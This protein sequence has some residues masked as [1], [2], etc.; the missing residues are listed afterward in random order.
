LRRLILLLQ[1]SLFIAL[2]L[3]SQTGKA[4]HAIKKQERSEKSLEKQYDKSKETALKHRYKIQSPEVK[5][6]M[7]TSRKK[8]D[9]YYKQK[10]KPVFKDLFTRKKRRR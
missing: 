4:R 8:V 5:E 2:P 10:N 3:H 9:Q 6:R 1:L 7:K